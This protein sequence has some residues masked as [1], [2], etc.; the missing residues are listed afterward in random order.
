MI[1]YKVSILLLSSSFDDEQLEL[2][3]ARLNS[4]FGK[5]LFILML[6]LVLLFL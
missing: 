3:T 4:F 1:F 2:K 6:L 5:L